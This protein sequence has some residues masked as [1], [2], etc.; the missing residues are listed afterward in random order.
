MSVLHIDLIKGRFRVNGHFTLT[1]L[2]PGSE[3]LAER[4]WSSE[5]LYSGDSEVHKGLLNISAGV[6]V[7][8]VC[9]LA[10][11]DLSRLKHEAK[12]YADPN[13]LL[14]LQGSYVPRFFGY[15]EC[16]CEW[17]GRDVLLGCMLLEYCGI[18][19]SSRLLCGKN[20]K[21]VLRHVLAGLSL[22]LLI[23]SIHRGEVVSAMTAIHAEAHL[24][25][26]DFQ[27]GTRHILMRG[28][29]ETGDLDIRII[30]FNEAFEHTCER[31]MPIEWWGWE[32]YVAE[33][34][35]EE[36]WNVVWMLG[37]W[38]PGKYQLY[39]PSRH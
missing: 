26:D 7:E 6:S 2:I 38:T 25:H 3:Y 16:E 34:G 8:A 39:C 21:Y 18:S 35:C 24:E 32:P 9:K 14:P 37:I 19:V 10:R 33:F 22:P 4:F 36:L 12:L 20:M 5:V 1:Q 15:Y 17:E 13:H 27:F 11:E 31:K 29:E 30:D 23:L 28:S